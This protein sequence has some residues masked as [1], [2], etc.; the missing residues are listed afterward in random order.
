M[1]ISF[2]TERWRGTRICVPTK[3]ADTIFKLQLKN[4]SELAFFK[5]C[6]RCRWVQLEARFEFIIEARRSARMPKCLI[7]GVRLLIRIQDIPRLVKQLSIH[8]PRHDSSGMELL[9]HRV[10]P[11]DG[12]WVV[13]IIKQ[14]QTSSS[15]ITKLQ[16]LIDNAL[17][18]P[19]A[20]TVPF[21]L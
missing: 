1:V 5:G 19:E 18:L 13:N 12:D 17:A 9:L 2:M 4:S 8:A 3:P 15:F 6:K 7:S 21:P 16:E 10:I 20:Q 11:H 14:Y